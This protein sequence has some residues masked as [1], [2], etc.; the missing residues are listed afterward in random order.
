MIVLKF[1]CHIALSCA[2]ERHA[3]DL[4][5]Q[6]ITDLAYRKDDQYLEKSTGS[7]GK[8]EMGNQVVTFVLQPSS[9]SYHA[10]FSERR[11]V[12]LQSWSPVRLDRNNVLPWQSDTVLALI[13]ELQTS[14]CTDAARRVSEV[15]GNCQR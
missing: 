10:G 13:D 2:P 7:M 1:F 15:R 6:E 5:L 11:G 9:P 4:A 8:H 3:S 14:E 12:D